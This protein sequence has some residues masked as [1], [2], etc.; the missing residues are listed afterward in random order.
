MISHKSSFDFI[1]LYHLIKSFVNR[2]IYFLNF[3]FMDDKLSNVYKLYLSGLYIIS[4]NM[5]NSNSECHIN[6]ILQ[7]LQKLMNLNQYNHC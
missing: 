7:I 6:I 3:S 2:I 4:F 5:C 1:D